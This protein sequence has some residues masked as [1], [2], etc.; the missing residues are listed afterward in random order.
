MLMRG[1]PLMRW[2]VILSSPPVVL[3]RTYR[4]SASALSR[5]LSLNPGPRFGDETSGDIRAKKRAASELEGATSGT[6]TRTTGDG[7]K[8][9]FPLLHARRRRPALGR[10]LGHLSLVSAGRGTSRA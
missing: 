10:C 3:R 1:P 9:E 8:L 5:H 4:D 2:I 7:D 6:R